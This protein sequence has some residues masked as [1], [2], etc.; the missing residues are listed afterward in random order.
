MVRHTLAHLWGTVSGNRRPAD[1]AENLL[2][3]ADRGDPV[4]V[5]ALLDKGTW[6]GR[7]TV[8]RGILSLRIVPG[9]GQI[10]PKLLDTIF[11][12]FGRLT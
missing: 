9:Q 3:A 11:D 12:G 4:E 5:Q 1:Q 6:R 10:S 8:E 2:D 7:R